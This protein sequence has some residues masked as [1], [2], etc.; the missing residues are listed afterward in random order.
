[1]GFRWSA[2]KKAD[3]LGLA[4]FI[5]N[6][7]DGGVFIEVEGE[8]EKLDEFVNWCRQG[9]GFAEVKS[10]DIEESEVKNYNTFSIV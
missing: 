9:P 5:S 8:E 1:M 10:V 4:G 3:V 7:P 6:R 2:K